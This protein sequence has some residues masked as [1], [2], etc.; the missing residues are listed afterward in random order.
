MPQRFAA[1]VHARTPARNERFGG[2]SPRSPGSR[3]FVPPDPSHSSLPRSSYRSHGTSSI[4][5][6]AVLRRRIP[7]SASQRPPGLLMIPIVSF[8][9][10][11]FRVSRQSGTHYFVASWLQ[12]A[13]AKGRSRHWIFIFLDVANAQRDRPSGAPAEEGSSRRCGSTLLS[14]RGMCTPLP[15]HNKTPVEI[16]PGRCDAADT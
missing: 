10:P 1:R 7:P 12:P 2:D 16:D 14:L 9:V 6:E 11:G 3:C 8:L 13:A 5:S 15:A 4:G